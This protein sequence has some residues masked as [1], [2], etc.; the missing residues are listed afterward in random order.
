MWMLQSIAMPA[1]VCG[2]SVARASAESNAHAARRGLTSVK[3]TGA[4]PVS[5]NDTMANDARSREHG[6]LG[7]HAYVAALKFVFDA[8]KNA[9]RKAPPGISSALA[10][11]AR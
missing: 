7:R 6:C 3:A 5:A 4:V 11:F 2:S 10:R 8:Q 9:L 1:S